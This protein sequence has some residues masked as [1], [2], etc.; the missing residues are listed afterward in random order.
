LG[1]EWSVN[2]GGG[3]GVKWGNDVIRSDKRE[4]MLSGHEGHSNPPF[5]TPVA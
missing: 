4:K 2:G 1:N 3:G 5:K